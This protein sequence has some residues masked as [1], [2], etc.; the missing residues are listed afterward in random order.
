MGRIE[1]ESSGTHRWGRDVREL[2]KENA[3]WAECSS[4]IPEG[5]EEVVEAEVLDNLEHR[6][7]TERAWL[8]RLEK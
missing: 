4:S 8:C 5:V 7:G 1:P 3:A 2:G 6:D